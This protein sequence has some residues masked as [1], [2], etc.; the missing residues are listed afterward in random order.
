MMPCCAS[1]LNGSFLLEFVTLYFRSLASS[2]GINLR[3]TPR[4]PPSDVVTAPTV[5]LPAAS[6]FSSSYSGGIKTG[7]ISSSRP[8]GIHFPY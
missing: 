4:R 6:Q 1:K 5:A 7:D 3:L 8:L 2:D